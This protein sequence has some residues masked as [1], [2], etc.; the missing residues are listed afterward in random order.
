MLRGVLLR[1]IECEF[2]L[3]EEGREVEDGGG[4][5]WSPGPS[6]GDGGR[7][8][9]EIYRMRDIVWE[10]V[11]VV[12]ACVSERVRE[13]RWCRGRI[14]MGSE[15]VDQGTK[16]QRKG[17]EEERKRGEREGEARDMKRSEKKRNERRKRMMKMTTAK[18]RD[19]A[20]EE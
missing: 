4:K 5:R 2:K 19:K 7:L 16:E 12:R 13:D 10:C 9:G 8:I 1:G 15:R 3:V 11:K 20:E 17:K 6:K 18:G 14:I